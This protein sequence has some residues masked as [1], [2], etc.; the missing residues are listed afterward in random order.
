MSEEDPIHDQ[1]VQA[2]LDYFKA[3]D[4]WERKKS[5]RAYYEVQKQTR[6]IRAL[7]KERNDELRKEYQA[8]NPSLRKANHKE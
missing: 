6:R 5:V 3:N 1:L 8:G 2:Y 4:W 7:A